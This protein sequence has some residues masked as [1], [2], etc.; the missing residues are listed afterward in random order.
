MASSNT[1]VPPMA[2][3]PGDTLAEKLQ[4][5]GLSANDCAV[6][7]G[8]SVD[9]VNAVLAQTLDVTD[10]TALA[11]EKVTE[12]PAYLW[13]RMQK[14]YN[15]FIQRDK[16]VHKTIPEEQRFRRPVVSYPMRGV[17]ANM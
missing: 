7:G 1:F 9:I 14:V 15:E 5:M 2:F 10:S 11:L 8:L 6:R 3:H 12:I 4:E 17:Y 13:L 16:E